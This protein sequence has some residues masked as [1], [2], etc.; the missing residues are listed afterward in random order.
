LLVSP[1]SASSALEVRQGGAWNVRLAAAPEKGH[2]NDAL[3]AETLEIPRGEVAP[4]AGHG[5]CDWLGSPGI[6]R[7][8]LE[9]R[10]E[11]CGA[12][13]RVR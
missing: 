6:V 8:E 7:E 3:L 11:L 5:A 12:A 13:G 2:A 10:L 4:V 1:G 9:R